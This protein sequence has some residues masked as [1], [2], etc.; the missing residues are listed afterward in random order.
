[1]RHQAM[2]PHGLSHGTYEAFVYF[3]N[4]ESGTVAVE[5]NSLIRIR[6]AVVEWIFGATVRYQRYV[7]TWT[8]CLGL[9]VIGRNGQIKGEKL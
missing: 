1:M 6:S 7:P 5:F 2:L 8:R 9:P 3:G 4:L